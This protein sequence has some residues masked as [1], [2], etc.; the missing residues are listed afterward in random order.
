VLGQLWVAA[1]RMI[2]LPLVI[3]LTLAA[4]VSAMRESSIGALGA[5]AFGLFL[6]CSWRPR[7]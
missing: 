7:V 3:A 2:V 1:L 5:K 6:P 4:I